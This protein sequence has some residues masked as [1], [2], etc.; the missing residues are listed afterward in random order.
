[1]AAEPPKYAKSRV[2]LLDSLERDAAEAREKAEV[3]RVFAMNI[4]AC[5]LRSY[6]KWLDSEIAECRRTC[7]L[8][9]SPRRKK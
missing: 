6:A 7:G 9:D 4:L 1:M 2:A 5:R 3:A 8:T